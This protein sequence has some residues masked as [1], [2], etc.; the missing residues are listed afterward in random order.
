MTT[1]AD[2]IKRSYYLAQVLDPREE[3]EGFQA[4]EGLHELN[5]V[6]DTWG[7]VSIYIPSYTI[8]TLSIL[9]NISSYDVT[10]VITQLSESHILDSNNVLYPLIQIDLQRFNTLNF[11]LS[12][13]SPTRPSEIFIQNDFANYPT[14]SKV[15]V[16]PVPD[17]SY[18]ATLYAMQRLNNVTYSQDLTQLPGYV[19]SALEYEMAKQLINIYGTT[20]AVT[21]MQDYEDTMRLLKAANRRDRSVQVQNEFQS[22]RRFKPW[23]IYVD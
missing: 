15:R 23:G 10:P 9:A 1:S 20:P 21:F 16:F 8:L 4:S 2:L 3:I 18:T 14:L 19:I 6:L 17:T 22:F 5:R 11:S 7:S 12:A 13:T